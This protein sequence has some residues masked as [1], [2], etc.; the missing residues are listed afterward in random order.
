[1]K[2]EELKDVSYIGDG[3]YVG[4]DGYQF[5]LFTSNG[6][7]ETNWIALEPSVVKAFNRYIKEINEKYNENRDS[8]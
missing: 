5:W 4:H 8:V 7:E 2:K 6:I 3:V 1:M